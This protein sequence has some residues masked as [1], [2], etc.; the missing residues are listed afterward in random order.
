MACLAIFRDHDILPLI[1]TGGA[2]E[3]EMNTYRIL[4]VDSEHEVRKTVF[5]SFKDSGLDVETTDNGQTALDLLDREPFDLVLTELVIPPVDGLTILKRAK[6][7]QPEIVVVILTGYLMTDAAVEA[8]RMGADDYLIKPFELEEL[9]FRIRKCI[10]KLEFRRQAGVSKLAL[11]TSEAEFRA[12]VESSSD[13]IFMLEL[14]GTYRFSNNRIPNNT[15]PAGKTV[16]GLS[17]KDIYPPQ[18]TRLYRKKLESLLRSGKPE[19]FQHTLSTAEGK[20]FYTDTLYPIHSEGALIAVGGI[21]R[22]ITEQKKLE[23]HLFQSQKMESLGTLVAGIAHEINNPLNLI[24]FNLPLIQKIWKDLEPALESAGK[25][26]PDAKYGG[27][28][29]AFLKENLFQM[30]L[31]MKTAADR[32]ASIV[33]GLKTF[34]RKTSPAEFKPI[35]VN[36]AVENALKLVRTTTRKSG[37]ELNTRLGENLP[38]ING[39]LQNIEQI[40]MNLVINALQAIDHDKGRIDVSTHYEA[41]TEEVRI[42]VTDNGKGIDADI[43]ETIFDPF[44][45][46]KQMEGGTGLGLSVTYGLVKNHGGDI[47]FETEKGKGTRFSVRLGVHPKH[48][49]F[50]ILVVDD[51]APIRRLIVKALSK[52]QGVIF[53]E[54]DNGTKAL[55][56]IGT[57]QPDLLILDIMMPEMDGLELCRVIKKE[58]ELSSMDVIIITGFINDSRIQKVTR[59]GFTHIFEKPLEMKSLR[60]AVASHMERRRQVIGV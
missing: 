25:G 47:T 20:F 54:A 34:S 1:V 5:E 31:D 36:E 13:H 59:L 37:V 14:D 27:L 17:L 51:E 46:D 49:P 15:L 57:F 44:V 35:Q 26:K 16:V 50:K 7:L 48:A 11:L 60:E 21:C 2:S 29:L 12:L 18:V 4:L 58:P 39:N 43:I 38:A 32:V 45:T 53:Q 30:I 22:D 19:I 33:K 28:T 8:F 6:E 56:K 23:S 42:E 40:V 41:E 9:K 55:I 52:E 24:M 3:K 10:E